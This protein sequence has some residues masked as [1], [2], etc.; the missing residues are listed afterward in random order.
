MISTSLTITLSPAL[1]VEVVIRVVVTA[2]GTGVIVET[3]TPA[4]V[5]EEVA[6]M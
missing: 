4:N 3:V 6:L 2:V 5:E 1:S